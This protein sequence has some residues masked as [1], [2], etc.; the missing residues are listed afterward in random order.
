MGFGLHANGS[1]VIA[2][3]WVCVCL[4]AGACV[5]KGARPSESGK[6]SILYKQSR[7]GRWGPGSSVFLWDGGWKMEREQEEL[8]ARAY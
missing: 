1:Q 3:R 5:S 6:L 7:E 4:C 2:S 8:S